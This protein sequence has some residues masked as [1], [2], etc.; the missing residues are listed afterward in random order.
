LGASPAGTG[1]KS[2]KNSIKKNNEVIPPWQITNCGN[3]GKNASKQAVTNS[4][5]ICRERMIQVMCCCCLLLAGPPPRT[6]ANGTKKEDDG[7][8]QLSKTNQIFWRSEQNRK[9]I[10]RKRG[11]RRTLWKSR[12]MQVVPFKYVGPNVGT[13][14]NKE[15]KKK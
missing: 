14:R 2:R 10:K 9:R 13:H 8:Y 1:E 4:E 6:A 11:K 7:G 3:A 12:C 5:G 15:R